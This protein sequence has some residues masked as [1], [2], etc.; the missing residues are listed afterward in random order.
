MRKILRVIDS[1]SGY[2]GKV[3]SWLCYALILV[4]VY[5]VTMRYVFTAPTM[6]AYETAIMLGGTIWALNWAYTHSLRAHVRVDV[7]YSH[8]SL[9]KR[10]IIDVVGT[11]FIFFPLLAVFIGAS[12][13]E[14]WHAWLVGE[15]SLESYWYPP[16]APFRTIVL[17]GFC[18][19]AFQAV[20]QFIRDLYI[21]VKS[22]SYD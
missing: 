7:I 2:A 3:G 12:F 18:L 20:A 19:I 14:M 17:I 16:L 5:D 13:S 8:R 1:V 15:V 4:V 11:L 6:W 21:L 9:R 22:K 10:A